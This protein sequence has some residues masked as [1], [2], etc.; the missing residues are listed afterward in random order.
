[1]QVTHRHDV[2]FYSSDES[3]VDDLTQFDGAAL[4]TGSAA[5]VIATESHRDS[6]LL[7]LQAHGLKAAN[8]YQFK[9]GQRK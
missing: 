8:G 5:I 9:T 7:R 2:G 3:L 6:L 4:R 1:M